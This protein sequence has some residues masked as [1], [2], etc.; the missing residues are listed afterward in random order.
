MVDPFMRLLSIFPL[1]FVASIVLVLTA[2]SAHRE[3]PAKGSALTEQATSFLVLY[4]RSIVQIELYGH[5]RKISNLMSD[6]VAYIP[7]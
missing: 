2:S 6:T 7:T 1:A 5:C 3:E 4:P